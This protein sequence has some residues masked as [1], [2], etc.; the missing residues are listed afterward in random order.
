MRFVADDKPV[1]LP[2]LQASKF[3]LVINARWNGDTLKRCAVARVSFFSFSFYRAAGAVSEGLFIEGVK[4]KSF[5]RS[6]PYRF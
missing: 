5:A 1:D 2:V 3:E 4:R 6:E